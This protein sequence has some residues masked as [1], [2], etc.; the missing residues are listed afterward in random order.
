MRSI[1]T[2]PQYHLKLLLE[3][4]GKRIFHVHI[5]DAWWGKGDGTVGTFGGHTSFGDARR[6]WRG[7]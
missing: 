7:G 6:T 5:K 4:M 1:E 2:H 3:R